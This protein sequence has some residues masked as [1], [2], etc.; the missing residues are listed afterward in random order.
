MQAKSTQAERLETA[1][2]EQVDTQRA[3]LTTTNAQ[4][5]RLIA[6]L[7]SGQNWQKQHQMQ[8]ARLNVLEGRLS[9]VQT[10][11]LDGKKLIIFAEKK[12]RREQRELA[13][14]RDATLKEKRETL[15]EEQGQH[16]SQAQKKA[17]IKARTMRKT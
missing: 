3:Q 12:L 13:A 9:R 7:W 6:S 5:P 8:Q 10:L 1:L 16:L 14:H 4:R 15:A 2:T 17:P 11:R